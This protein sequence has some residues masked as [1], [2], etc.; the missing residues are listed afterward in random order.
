MKPR[1]VCGAV[2]V[3]AATAPQQIQVNNSQIRSYSTSAHEVTKQKGGGREGKEDV[4]GALG[5]AGAR[6]GEVRPWD[7]RKGRGR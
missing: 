4:W 3:G 1:A 2:A 6:K 7:C 5:G